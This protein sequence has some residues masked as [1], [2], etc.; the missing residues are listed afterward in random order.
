MSGS[1]RMTGFEVRIQAWSPNQPNR[2]QAMTMKTMPKNMSGRR[3]KEVCMNTTESVRLW[4][5]V[6]RKLYRLLGLSLHFYRIPWLEAAFS[7]S[8]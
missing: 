6:R 2:P 4:K 5:R 1:G 7:F 3:M 8:P